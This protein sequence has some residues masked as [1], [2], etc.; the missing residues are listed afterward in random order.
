MS[1]CERWLGLLDAFHDGELGLPG[2][3]RVQWHLRRC[4]RCR[5]ELDRLGEVGAWVRRGEGGAEGPLPDLWS[6]IAARLPALDR[7]LERVRE[8]A[9]ARRWIP[10]LLVPLGAGVAAAVVGVALFRASPPGVEAEATMGV[11]RAL[12]PVDEPIIVL[13]DSSDSTIIWVM[14]PPVD[15]RSEGADHVVG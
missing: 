5:R 13:E 10:G 3:W 4:D 7:E 14:D 15:Q 2:H 12:Y 6:Q 8:E 1:N 9:P 11:V